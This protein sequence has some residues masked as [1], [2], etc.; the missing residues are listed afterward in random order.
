[1]KLDVLYKTLFYISNK[2]QKGSRLSPEEL[3][4]LFELVDLNIMNNLLGIKSPIQSITSQVIHE[5]NQS[6]TDKIKRFKVIKGYGQTVPLI[7]TTGYFSLP[8]D[9]LYPSVISYEYEGKTKEIEILND[10]DF[11]SRKSDVIASPSMRYPIGNF[12]NGLIWVLPTNISRVDFIYIRKPITAFFDYYIS[13]TNGVVYLEP[14]TTYTL[15]SG[16][17]YRTGQTTGTVTSQSKELDFNDEM[18]PEYLKEMLKLMG[19]NL[20]DAELYQAI[21]Q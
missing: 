5:I 4:R 10:T 14:N 8:S 13:P 18:H 16:E 21:N 12:Q 7:S 6:V 19:I 3:N 17:E 9:Y 15:Q 20:R 2:D 1:M 11:I